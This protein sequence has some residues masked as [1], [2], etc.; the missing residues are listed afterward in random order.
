M[1]TSRT[2]KGTRRIM[3]PPIVFERPNRFS[4]YFAAKFLVSKVQF[5]PKPRQA[6][7]DSSAADTAAAT[8][9]AGSTFV[10]AILISLAVR[11]VGGRISQKRIGDAL[12]AVAGG[13][14][15]KGTARP[16]FSFR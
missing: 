12:G 13:V 7:N 10:C 5:R 14:F 15:R 6:R 2:P 1:L 3:V 4:P 11:Y 16:E 9:N 8:A